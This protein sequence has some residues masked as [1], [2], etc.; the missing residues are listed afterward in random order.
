MRLSATHPDS[1]RAA[2][3]RT[4]PCTKLTGA[5]LAAALLGAPAPLAASSLDPW[6]TIVVVPAH[7]AEASPYDAAQQAAAD[8]DGTAPAQPQQNAQEAAHQDVPED[9]YVPFD[10]EAETAVAPSLWTLIELGLGGADEPAADT[11]A[12]A[13]SPSWLPSGK[14]SVAGRARADLPTRMDLQQGAAS[15]SVSSKASAVAP[16]SGAL[17][18]TGTSGTGEITGKVG[19]LQDY[20]TVYTAG[21]VGASASGSTANLYDSLAVGSTYSVP[22]APVGLGDQK[23]GASVELND[24]RTVTTGVELRAP[25]GAAERFISVERTQGPDSAGSGIVKAGVL[26]KF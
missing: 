18:T 15:L 23:L 10:P 1:L 3:L 21:T 5:L 14:D 6:Q 22:L 12:Q 9:P 24:S 25:V 17:S 8:A 20:V 19:L 13:A 11:P 2:S 26:G 16:A 7:E 4:L